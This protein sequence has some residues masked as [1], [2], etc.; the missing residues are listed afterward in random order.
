MEA[1]KVQ[2]SQNSRS[3]ND[4]LL[5]ISTQITILKKLTFKRKIS[6]IVSEAGGFTI[7]DECPKYSAF[8]EEGKLFIGTY[9]GDIWFDDD[10][11]PYLVQIR[12]YRKNNPRG[13]KSKKG[14]KGRK[15][16]CNKR[17]I[18]KLKAR[19]SELEKG[20]SGNKNNDDNG[21]PVEENGDDSDNSVG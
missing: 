19:F 8:T 2:H 12:E 13:T 10:V 9:P 20:S 14:K 11:K 4:I 15:V 5:E 18:K 16:N 6:E 17:K 3:F 21:Q 1:L 7:K